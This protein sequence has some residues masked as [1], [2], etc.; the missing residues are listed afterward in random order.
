MRAD[1]AEQVDGELVPI[2]LPARRS[3]DATVSYP[4]PTRR[5][6][7]LDVGPVH[8]RR[9]SLAGMAARGERGG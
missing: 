5:R 7:V 3:G 6:G 1:V 4:I 2:D 8:V 9:S